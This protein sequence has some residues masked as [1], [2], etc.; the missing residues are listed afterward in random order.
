VTIL[1][2]HRPCVSIAL[3]NPKGDVLLV[4]KP[5]KRDAW[6]LP[7][8]GVEGAQSLEEAARR[9][10]LE[11]TGIALEAPPAVTRH[12]YQ[13]DYPPGFI[14]VKKPRYRGQHLTFLIAAVPSGTV[15]KI[16]HRELDASLWIA[17]FD[18]G[19]YVKR[20]EYLAVVRKVI[21]EFPL[22]RSEQ[23]LR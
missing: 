16:D 20:E 23:A 10:L 18:L 8:G 22:L 14:R 4:H 6:Q 17:P 2:L 1:S 5:R 3:L 9:E 15:V 7:Q 19:K 13:Y 12:H 21:K 11:E